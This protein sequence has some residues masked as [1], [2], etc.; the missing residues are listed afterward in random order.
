MGQVISQLKTEYNQMPEAH[1]KMVAIA[2]YGLSKKDISLMDKNS[3]I[4]S[5]LSIEFK[6][7][8]K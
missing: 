2:S 4:D 3:L 1:L 7:A 6:N 8:Y 5:M